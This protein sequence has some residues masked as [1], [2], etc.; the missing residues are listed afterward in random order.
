MREPL[1]DKSRLEHI[2]EAIETI[3]NRCEGLTYNSLTA[4]KILF[5]GIVYH[6]MIIGEA[7]FNLSKAFQ[8]EHNE[9]EWREIAKMRH[10]LV[11]G[12][13]QV[14]PRIVWSVIQHDLPSL[15]QQVSRYLRE[16]NWDEWEKNL[17]VINETAVHKSLLQTAARMKQRGYD[18]NEICKITGLSREEIDDIN[19]VEL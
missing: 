2:L 10:N 17:V 6:T 4:D 14:D 15:R 8:Q 12:Y 3:L 16:T 18:T 11:H 1:R 7:A 19:I 9:T 13:Y 5:G